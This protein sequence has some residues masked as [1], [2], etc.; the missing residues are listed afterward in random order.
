MATIRPRNAK[1]PFE[2][3]HDT[4]DRTESLDEEEDPAMEV[5]RSDIDEIEIEEDE[6]QEED[7]SDASEESDEAVD[8]ALQ[9]EMLKFQDTFGAGITERFRLI[10]RIG[11]GTFSTV[12]KAEDLLYDHYDND[13]DL[14]EKENPKWASPPMKKRRTGLQ[15]TISDVSQYSQQ[16]RKPRY[17]AIKKIYV[18]SSPL[19]I[20]NEI[21]LLSKLQGCDSVCPLITAF[22][23]TDQVVAVLPYFKHT[24]F[25]E[26][27]RKMT[28]KDMQ[29]YFR[30]LFTAL[31]AT[32]EQG[33]L[34]RDIKPTNFL[35]DPA[36]KRGVL[37]DFGLAEKEGTDY[38]P[39]LCQG[40]SQRDPERR[41]RL[42][43]SVAVAMGPSSGY[44]KNDSRPS[45]R[46]NRAGTRGFRA[47]E[48]LFKCTAQSTKIDIWSAGVMLLTILSKRFPF[49]N[50]ADDVEAMIEIATIF[51]V[52]K[53]K[54]CAYLHGAMFETTIPTIGDKGFNLEKII[55][56]STCRNDGGKG[57][58]EIPLTDEEKM[59]VRFLE[60]CFELDPNKRISAA[61]ALEHDFLRE[62]LY[63]ED[64]EIQMLEA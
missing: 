52:K 56:W 28:V 17:V 53:M 49:F 34:H 2:I 32:H 21:E 24:D 43:N 35:Y 46:A 19:R 9:E 44:P 37:V 31:K 23:H 26:Y 4:L 22:R 50:S 18:T 42:Q 48:V 27:F 64:D 11:E 59:A 57:G 12:Y 20:L 51:G 63:S 16:R 62:D 45:R 58:S 55:L 15:R 14:E 7:F 10:G 54:Q 60:R 5:S 41:R 38:K 3:H 40:G 8:P 1:V 36:K 6:T 29:I 47:P 25:R 39:C 30:S 13:W 33:I 61:E